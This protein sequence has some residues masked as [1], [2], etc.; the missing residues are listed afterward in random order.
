MKQLSRNVPLGEKAAVQ[1]RNPAVRR[2]E[3]PR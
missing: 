3:V 2:E 1:P